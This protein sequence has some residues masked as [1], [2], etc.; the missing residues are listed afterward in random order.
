M[1]TLAGQTGDFEKAIGTFEEILSGN[2]MM[3]NVQVEAAKVLELWAQQDGQQAKYNEAIS[4]ASK[5]VWGWAKIA[6][7][8]FKYQKFRDTFH[9]ARIHL[10]ECRLNYA[11]I[12]SG[13]AQ[14]NMLNQAT[15]EL[16]VTAKLIP[17]LGGNAF[18]AR[19]DQLLKKIQTA[20]GER[21][22]GLKAFE[23]KAAAGG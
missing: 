11:M 20:Q 5:A 12:K 19:Y 14:K 16:S 17:D 6:N 10:G 23:S 13:D 2:A 22:V 1:A 18:K 9:E 15:Q 4:G 3:L 8:T 7:T 21:A